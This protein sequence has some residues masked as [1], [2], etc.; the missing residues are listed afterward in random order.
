MK[1]DIVHVRD[2][3]PDEYRDYLDGQRAIR[4]IDENSEIRG[5][6][7]WKLASRWKCTFEIKEFG[8][9]QDSDRRRGWGTILLQ[10]AIDDMKRYI[11]CV[12][13]RYKAWRIYLFC[14]ERNAIARKF[15]EVRGFQKEAMLKDFYGSDDNAILYSL[16]LKDHS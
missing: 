11:K 16:C 10:A 4:I 8:I 15:Y 6:L 13:P 9:F 14:E 1:I 7:V 3:I 5:E 12:D 2:H